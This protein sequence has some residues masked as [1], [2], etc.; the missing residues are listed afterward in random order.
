LNKNIN[1]FNFPIEMTKKAIEIASKGLLQEKN[2]KNIL[3]ISVKGGG[4]AGLKYLL[5]F[6]KNKDNLD[7]SKNINGLNIVIDIFSAIH[8]NGT[9]IDYV[10][11][12]QESGF[13]FKNPSAK[14]TCG[15]G[16]SFS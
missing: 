8:L 4:C 12:L 15:C 9:T 10:Q 2:N 11:S 7:I 16:S 1:K 3:R 5:N 13:K 14:R 6:V